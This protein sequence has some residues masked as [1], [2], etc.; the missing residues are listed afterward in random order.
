MNIVLVVNFEKDMGGN[1]SRAVN[2]ILTAQGVQVAV[3]SSGQ[4][5]PEG[6]DLIITFGGDGTLLHAS[7]Q[8]AIRSIPILGIN[9]GHLGFLT[10]L[11]GSELS[12][13]ENFLYK[14]LRVE[15]RMLLHMDLI[16]GN[17]RI[18]EDLAL[19]DI[20]VSHGEIMRVI[21]LTLFC[22]QMQVKDFRGDGLIVS[23]P[24]GST[25]Y[26]LS[27]GGP[28]IDPSAESMTATPL[29]AH[30]IYAKSFVFSANR[31]VTISV[32]ALENRS[33]FLSADGREAIALQ[34]GDQVRIRKADCYLSLVKIKEESFFSTLYRK[35]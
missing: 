33:A 3:I 31:V 18:A 13:L 35:L 8:A 4:T 29:N 19:N 15:K 7:R 22:D 2:D 10:S 28:V 26:S 32:G 6:C 12:L 25:A 34:S 23:S 9:T 17:Q 27:A 11:E 20:V 21:P 1:A 30:V 16:R 5:V 24:T 14:P